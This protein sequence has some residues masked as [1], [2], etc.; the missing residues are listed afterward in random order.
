MG[1][2]AS[3]GRG[4]HRNREMLAVTTR[5]C[6]TVESEEHWEEVALESQP[7]NVKWKREADKELK[8]RS[9]VKYLH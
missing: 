1:G 4:W 6:S 8:V 3:L 2:T 7:R 9:K 5:A